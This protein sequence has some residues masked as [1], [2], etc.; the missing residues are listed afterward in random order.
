VVQQETERPLERWVREYEHDPEFIADGLA[1]DVIEDALRLLQEKN[2][3]QTWLAGEMGVS[4]AHVSRLFNAPPNLT[5]LSFAR[6]AVALGVKPRV[7]LD[8]GNVFIREFP[9]LGDSTPSSEELITD[10]MEAVSRLRPG[11]NSTWNSVGAR[12]RGGTTDATV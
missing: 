8:S 11:A 10:F 5:L 4:R 9:R 3:T 6:L 1:S 2:H 7:F 12:Q